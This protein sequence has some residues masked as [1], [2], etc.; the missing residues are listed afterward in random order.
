VIGVH[1]QST[2]LN[3][4]D[5]LYLSFDRDDEAWSVHSRFASTGT[6]T[7]TDSRPP[8]VRPRLDIRWRVP[9]S[10]TRA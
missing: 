8:P 6:S 10:P 4:L 1:M 7:V 2:P 5:E 3:V 9:A